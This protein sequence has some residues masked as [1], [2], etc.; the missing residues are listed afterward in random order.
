MSGFFPGPTS[1]LYTPG[2]TAI[3][4]KTTMAFPWAA[5][6]AGASGALSFLGQRRANK[7][8]IA[9]A[10]EQMAFQERMSNTAYQ[11]ARADMKAAGLNPIL[12]L[13]SPASSPGGQTARVDNALAS[14]VGSAAQAAAVAGQ[15]KQIDATTQNIKAD[16][17]VKNVSAD[18]AEKTVDTQIANVKQELRKMIAETGLVH[19]G[20][21]AK[22]VETE[23]NRLRIPEFKTAAAFYKWLDSKE[24]NEYFSGFK[25]GLGPVIQVILKGLAV[26]T[27]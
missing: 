11:R 23:I 19:S 17:R 16:T 20:I 4:A 12:A 22:N 13:G 15:L 21:S 3:G 5:A 24:A 8:N 27:R 9:L 26:A 25:Y 18:V 1:G 7:Q 6:A 2:S 10:R 14:G